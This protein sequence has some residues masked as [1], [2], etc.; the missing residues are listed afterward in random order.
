[1]EVN[2]WTF[3]HNRLSIV[4]HNPLSN[5]PFVSDCGK[6]VIV[7]NGEVYNHNEIREKLKSKYNFIY[8]STKSLNIINL[9]SIKKFLKKDKKGFYYYA[10]F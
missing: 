2:N 1:M 6:Y 8:P 4:D 3:G 7:F 5:Q 9:T 10:K